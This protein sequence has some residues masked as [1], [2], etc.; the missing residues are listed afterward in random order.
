MPMVMQS[1]WIA[2]DALDREYKAGQKNST[3]TTK[4]EN[5]SQYAESEAALTA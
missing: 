2:A 5:S 3:G 1:G 4:T